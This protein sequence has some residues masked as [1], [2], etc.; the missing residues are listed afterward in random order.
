MNDVIVVGAG[1]IGSHVARLLAER[2]LDVLVLEKDRMIGDSV[3]CSGIISVEAFAKLDLPRESIQNQLQKIVVV[4]PSGE[5]VEYEPKEPWAHI[6][7]RVS[8]DCQM[9]EK[10]GKSGAAYRL[11]SWV[12]N[13]EF[14]DDGVS[15][16]VQCKEGVKIFR[17]K[18]CVLATGFGAKFIQKVNLGKIHNYIQGVQ[19]EA[20]VRDVEKVE[21]FLGHKIA[22]GSFA[23]VVPIGDG[24]CKIG[25][26]ANGGGGELL[27]RFVES[28]HLAPRLQDWD[29]TVKASLIPMG[30]LPKAFAERILVVGEAAG[31]VKITT[32][33]GIYYGLLCAE[34]AAEVLGH[35]FQKNDFSEESLAVYDSEWR[36]LLES[37]LNAGM[38]LRKLFSKMSDRN[39]DALINLAQYD[40]IVPLVNKVFRFDW[41][42]P[43]ISALLKNQ[44]KSWAVE[45]D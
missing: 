43:L 10:A 37:E 20:V 44:L 30:T 27:Q 18:A 7:D 24:R 31:Q 45:A 36:A 1:C 16:T 21:I 19:L 5:S 39:I 38:T 11:E 40:G 41:H 29:G 26:L 13:I 22:P 42:A 12:E 9:A 4:G 3:N 35:A 32:A 14:G 8:F 2:G 17:A 25:L 6:V 28:T 23:W 15:L 33:G 34:I